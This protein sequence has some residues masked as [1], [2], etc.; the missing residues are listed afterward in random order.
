MSNK[1]TPPHGDV[2]GET[3]PRFPSGPWVGFWIQRIAGKHRM[4]CHLSFSDGH[5]VGTGIDVVGRFTM[6]GTYDLKAGR[7]LLTKQYEAAHR[8]QYD[9]VSEGSEL[10]LWGIWQL[11]NDRG[12]FHIWPEGMAD[13]TQRRLK[14]AQDV[15]TR[16]AR[17]ISLAPV[18]AS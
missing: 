6:E 10:W 12:G 13:P 11:S 2:I 16:T 3:D 14:A 4:R 17:R 5:V 8:L 9:G 15:P 1:E 18:S 7:C